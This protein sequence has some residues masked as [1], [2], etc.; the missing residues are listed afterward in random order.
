VVYSFRSA[1]ASDVVAQRLKAIELSSADGN[2]EK[3]SVLELIPE[4]GASLVTRGEQQMVGK[5]RS[6]GFGI[7]HFWV[8]GFPK[9]F[10][11]VQNIFC[12]F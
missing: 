5:D 10:F 2:W 11:L 8:W 3:A 6:P 9:A 4:D 12:G 7:L 1:E